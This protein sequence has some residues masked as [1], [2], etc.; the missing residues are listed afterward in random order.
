[1][2]Y[3]GGDDIFLMEKFNRRF[4]GQM[5]YL[6]DANAVVKTLPVTSWKDW[7]AQRMRWAKKS[8]DLRNQSGT[9]FL[10]LQML[11]YF[12][13]VIFLVAALIRYQFIFI[14]ALW[15]MLIYGTHYILLKQTAR[16][17][18]VRFTLAEFLIAQT[19]LPFSYFRLA[20]FML[21]NKEFE[22]KKRKYT[23]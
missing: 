20:F 5:F 16:K 17:Y 8:T 7:L 22:W 6:A 21:L 14:F 3:A 15:M 19:L 23:Q 1:M 13:G 18:N 9:K 10:I 12:E 4:P 11:A 2:H